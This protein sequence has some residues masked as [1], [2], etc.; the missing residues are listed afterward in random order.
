MEEVRKRIY[1]DS[2]NTT[3]VNREVL[4]EMMP[5]FN[6]VFGDPTASYS[7]GRDAKHLVDIARMRVERAINAERDEIYFTSCEEES[8]NW[9]ILGLARA[10]RK[11]GKHIITSKAED[12]SILRACKQLEAEGFDVTYVGCD[13]HGVVS[14]SQIMHA[15]RQD[16]ILVSIQVA[17]NEVGTIQHL[18][19][20]ART[21]REKDIIFHCDAS[22]AFGF[23]PLDVKVLPIDAMTLSS[24]KIYGPKG[25]AALYVRDGVNIDG[26]VV[27]GRGEDGK[28]AGVPNTAS[29]VGFGKAVELATEN[30][31]LNAKKLKVARDYLVRGL[32]EKIEGVYLNGHQHQRLGYIANLEFECVDNQCLATLL[33]QEGIAVG[34]CGCRRNPS[35][36]LL[37]MG[38]TLEQVNSSIRFSI[39]KNVSKADLDVVIEKTASFV[40][41]LREVSPLRKNSAKE[42]K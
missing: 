10:N 36:T 19:A 28:R 31:A 15:M 18:N 3:Y 35:S 13:E 26:F 42:S 25:V 27:G 23:F 4:A 12:E 20:I 41:K 6:S 34:V 17:N 33:D 16:T 32:M 5:T 40:K 37:A 7:Y 21:V 2:A 39:A 22:T 9:A 38:K 14:L 30:I 1:L 11:R 29:V 24:Q 8:N